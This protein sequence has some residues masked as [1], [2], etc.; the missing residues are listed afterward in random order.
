MIFFA[1]SGDPDQTPHSAASYP[2]LHC[3]PM[4]H[5][6]DARLIWV[7]IKWFHWI[8]TQHKIELISRMM[9]QTQWVGSDEG[10][11]P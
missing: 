8:K 6:I 7:I 9:N 10:P 2:S 4:S 11:R 3:L 5:K 1:N